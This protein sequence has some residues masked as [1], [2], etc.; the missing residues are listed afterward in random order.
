[1][2]KRIRGI[3]PKLEEEAQTTFS[4]GRHIHD[5]VLIASKA[6]HW[7]KMKTKPDVLI[8]L[9]FHKA[10]DKVRWEF[11]DHILERMGFGGT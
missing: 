10:Y 8:K 4:S 7:M 6:I 5:G 1:M 3:V 11:L 9:E 2:A